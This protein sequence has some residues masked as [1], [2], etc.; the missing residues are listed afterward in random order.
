M[1]NWQFRRFAQVHQGESLVIPPRPVWRVFRRSRL[2]IRSRVRVAS[3][4]RSAPLTAQAFAVPLRCDGGSGGNDNSRG[5]FKFGEN[6]YGFGKWLKQRLPFL[7]SD[8]AYRFLSVYHRFG[9]TLPHN[10]LEFTIALV[11]TVL[12]ALAAPSTPESAVVEIISRAQ[13]K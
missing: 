2:A 9:E 6:D 12:Y 11:P 10:A 8:S 7:S 1:P 13:V 4:R 3:L 5:F